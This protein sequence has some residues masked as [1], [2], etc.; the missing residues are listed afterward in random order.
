M[1]VRVERFWT[2][3]DLFSRTC[4]MCCWR[5]GIHLRWLQLLE[6]GVPHAD[7]ALKRHHPQQATRQAVP[8]H[9]PAAGLINARKEADV[10]GHPTL[11]F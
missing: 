11:V 7:V 9:K 2:I 4:A 5:E 10:N 6:D 8:Q 3:G 1:Y